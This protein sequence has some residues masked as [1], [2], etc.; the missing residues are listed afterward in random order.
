MQEISRNF[1]ISMLTQRLIR[2][3]TAFLCCDLQSIFQNTIHR[4][5]HVTH[6]ASA[7]V[8]G[9]KV[10]GVPV[11]I[12]EQYPEKLGHTVPIIE[13]S[14]CTLYSKTKFSMLT[15]AF[16]ASIR[17]KTTSF[18]LFG[19]EAHVCVHQTAL[20]LLNMGKHV[21]IVTDAVSS[22]RPLDRTTAFHNL[23][24]AGAS[25]MTAES[26]LFELM[27]SKDVPEFK[28]ISALA[29]SIAAFHKEHPESILS[30]L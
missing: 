20:D 29:K 28:E 9:A 1:K 24:R 30:S 21:V 23:S 10:L 19:I 16:P 5:E 13:T 4:F 12:S 17:D 22:S 7:L 11:V 26:V 6:T 14:G 25:L 2:N 3:K 15:E 18:V 27:Q 8:K